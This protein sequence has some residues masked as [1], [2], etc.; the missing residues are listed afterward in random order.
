V[1]AVIKQDGDES[2]AQVY[3]EYVGTRLAGLLGVPAAAGVF[4]THSRGLRY[5]SLMIAEVAPAPWFTR[6]T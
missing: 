2:R 4:V 5:A 3:S 6:S 1:A